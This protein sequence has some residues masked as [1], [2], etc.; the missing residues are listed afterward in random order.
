MEQQAPLRIVVVD[1][2]ELGRRRI[3]N[4]LEGRDDV[5]IIAECADAETAIEAIQDGHPDILFLDVHMPEVDGFQLLSSLTGDRPYV[6]LATAHEEHALR[7]FQEEAVDFLLKPFDRRRLETALQRAAERVRSRRR[8]A[9]LNQLRSVMDG[10]ESPDATTQQDSL[11]TTKP[12]PLRKLVVKS[13]ARKFLIDISHIRWIEAADYYA[14]VYT[15]DA[16]HL[17]RRSLNWLEEHLPPE[18]F[19]RIHRSSIVNVEHVQEI[20]PWSGGSYNVLLRDGTKLR[21]SGGRKG[22]LERLLGQSL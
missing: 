14:R 15:A 10:G 1:D 8:D 6:I 5:R 2:E 12:A 18:Q 13:Q 17:V 11:K 21:L 20:V 22:E 16:S 3:V 9:L 19:V 7:G 4:L